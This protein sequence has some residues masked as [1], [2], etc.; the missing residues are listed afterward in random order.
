MFVSRAELERYKE[1]VETSLNAMDKK[2][3]ILRGRHE[4]LLK[5]L[6]LSECEIPAKTELRSKG[7]PEQGTS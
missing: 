1:Y 3:W 5:H 7:G 2:Y 4:I 6:G